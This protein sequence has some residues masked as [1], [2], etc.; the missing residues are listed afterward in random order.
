MCDAMV[1]PWVPNQICG[2]GPGEREGFWEIPFC[3]VSAGMRGGKEEATRRRGDE[4]ER[5]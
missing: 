3:L 4:A 1:N 2:S 5:R